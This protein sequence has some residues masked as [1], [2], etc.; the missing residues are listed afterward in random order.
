MGTR[1]HRK[2]RQTVSD[3]PMF[4]ETPAFAERWMPLG[5]PPVRT[6]SNRHLLLMSRIT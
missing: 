5:S 1:V 4:Q 2:T 3:A 6:V